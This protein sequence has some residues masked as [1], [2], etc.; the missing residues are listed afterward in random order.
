MNWKTLFDYRLD[1][2]MMVSP[3]V[4]EALHQSYL[5]QY[6][7]IQWCFWLLLLVQVIWLVRY[8]TVLQLSLALLWAWL[9]YQYVY[10]TLGQ[11]ILAGGVLAGIVAI[12]SCIHLL[13]ALAGRLRPRLLRSEQKRSVKLRTGLGIGIVVAGLAPWQAI[14]TGQYSLSLS[15]GLGVLPTAIV[16]IG[17]VHLFCKGWY[18]WLAVPLP[19]LS[20]LA[21]LILLFGLY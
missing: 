1:D 18:R 14:V 7:L 2:V 9:A 16:T 12:Q 8:P 6:V 5:Q 11:V 13:L 10:Q 19:V 4:Y 20:I 15:Y 21:V 17:F 3:E